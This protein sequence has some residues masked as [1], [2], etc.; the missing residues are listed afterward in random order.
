MMFDI[1]YSANAKQFLKRA[2]KH[3]TRRI[4]QRTERLKDTPVPSDAR[5]IERTNG[6]KIFRVRIGDYRALYKVDEKRKVVLVIKIDKRSRV[7][8]R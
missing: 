2:E 3:I 8:H 1:E 4:M 7:Y 5:F 6:D